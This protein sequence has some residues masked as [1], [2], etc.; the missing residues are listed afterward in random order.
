MENFVDDLRDNPGRAI[1]LG[2]SLMATVWGIS[3]GLKTGK[4]NPDPKQT[5]L[6]QSLTHDAERDQSIKTGMEKANDRYDRNCTGVFQ[7]RTNENVYAPLTEGI[8]VLSGDYATRA[9]R[10]RASKH[11]VPRPT[12][13][14]YLPAGMEVCDAYG[15]TAYLEAVQGSN[16]VAVMTDLVPTGDQGRIKSMTDR[17]PGFKPNSLKAN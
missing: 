1:V 14:D 17:Y 7:F 9:D 2:F 12:K 16:G 11:P 13:A 10:L 6:E 3:S 15:N 8:G 4:F 5:Q